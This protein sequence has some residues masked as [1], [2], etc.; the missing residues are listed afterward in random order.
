M[1]SDHD[2]TEEPTPWV[3]GVI[4]ASLTAVFSVCV[5]VGLYD[6]V[7]QTHVLLGLAAVLVVCAGAGPTAWLWRARPVLRWPGWG[8][9]VGLSVGLAIV[10]V[11]TAAARR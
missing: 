2:D 8:A 3:P 6:V 7:A 9:I 1:R 10:V 4:V 5:L 11:L